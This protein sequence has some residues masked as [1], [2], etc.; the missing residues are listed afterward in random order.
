MKMTEIR[1]HGRGGHGTVTA[2]ILLAEAAVQSGLVA[3]TFP[4][5]GP[6]RRGNPVLVFT[7]VSSGPI[8]ERGPIKAPDVV[9][10]MDKAL[11]IN[12]GALDGLKAESVLIINTTQ[13]LVELSRQVA[14]LLSERKLKVVAVDATGIAIEELGAPFASTTILGA[15]IRATG[16]VDLEAISAA[17]KARLPVADWDRNL[18]AIQRAHYT[19]RQN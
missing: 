7:R 3:R 1:W 5:F 4:N 6:F 9:V 16:I 2:G 12:G 11:L 10:V 13:E 17:V 15:V 18:R 14:G 19:A 8:R